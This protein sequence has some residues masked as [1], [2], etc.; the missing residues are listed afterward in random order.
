MIAK[1][2]ANQEVKERVDTLIAKLNQDLWK[3]NHTIWSNPELGFKEYKAHDTIC[4]F[5]EAQGF[6]VTRHAYGIETAFEARSGSGGR[7]VNF[8]AEYDAL[9]NIGHACGHNLIA[10][11]SLAAFLSLSFALR[12]FGLPGRTQLLGTP[13][14]ESGGGKVELL[15]AGAYKDVDVSLMAHGGP[16]KMGSRKPCDGI[17]GVRM[18]AREQ[19]FCDFEGKNAHAGGNPWDGINALDAFVA[20]Y[21]NLSMLRQQTNDTDRIH[22]AI[23]EAPKA[24]NIIPAQIRAMFTTR[25]E[26]LKSLKALTARVTKCIEAGA[27]ATGCTLK[28]EKEAYYADIVVNDTLCQRYKAHGDEYGLDVLAT[29]PEIMTG[30][31]DIGNIS[32]AVPTLHSMFAIPCPEGSYPHHPSFANAAGEAAAHDPT[33]VVGKILALLGWDAIMDDGFYEQ[34][35]SEWVKSVSDT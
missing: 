11:S 22:S 15:N 8:N 29:T 28:I 34:V 26:T 17:A 23:L 5:L 12:D 27:L 2:P 1:L 14:E 3:V 35:K 31:S 9:P 33:L 6:T 21:N 10:T 18:V 24:A 13:A 4:D 20:S 19:L 30:S 7:L 32:Y 16:K 25:S